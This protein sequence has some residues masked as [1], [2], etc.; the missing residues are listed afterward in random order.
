MLTEMEKERL[1]T[2]DKLNPH[3]RNTNDLRVRR[4]LK[5]WLDDIKDIELI[6]D[7]LPINQINKAI[8]KITPIYLLSLAYAM[9]NVNRNVIFGELE[10]PD[11]WKVLDMGKSKGWQDDRDVEDLDIV[12][13]LRMLFLIQA[14]AFTAGADANLTMP[15]S[16]P[17][18]IVSAIRL[19]EIPNIKNRL[20]E[21]E[22]KGI[23]RIN[24]ARKRYGYPELK[25]R[26]LEPLSTQASTKGLKTPL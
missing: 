14:L 5:A 20:T 11:T 16:L 1:R 17:N 15:F 9:K 26:Q 7:S 10:Y 22:K 8:N 12:L 2:R 3:T 4:K 18:P 19:T 21:G 24:K 23:E 13:S 25:F 6:L